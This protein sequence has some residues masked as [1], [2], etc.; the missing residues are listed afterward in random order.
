M[1][2]T[3]QL[4]FSPKHFINGSKNQIK[5]IVSNQSL[6]YNKKLVASSQMPFNL[7]KNTSHIR[8]S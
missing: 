4:F 5:N 8:D 1:A 3:Y 6:L 2:I 7:R